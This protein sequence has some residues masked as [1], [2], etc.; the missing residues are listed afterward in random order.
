[1]IDSTS[2]HVGTATRLVEDTKT[3][4]EVPKSLLLSTR[5]GF[6]SHEHLVSVIIIELISTLYILWLYDLMLCC[7][8]TY[9]SMRINCQLDLWLH[10]N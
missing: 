2:I 3:S 7:V 9:T 10:V 1:M 6:L 4:L 5:L 8:D